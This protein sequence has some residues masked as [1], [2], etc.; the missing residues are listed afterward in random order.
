M[1]RNS[2]TPRRDAQ[3]YGEQSASDYSRY[4]RS[5]GA[6]QQD[7]ARYSRSSMGQAAN[8]TDYSQPVDASRY[9]RENVALQQK[10]ARRKRRN[11][12]IFT[13]VGVVLLLVVVVGAGAAFAYYKT[14]SDNLSKGVTD[15][16]LQALG[17]TTYTGD[18]FYMLLLGT[19]GASWR[20]EDPEFDGIY[21]TDSMMLVRVDP[22]NVQVSMISLQRDTLVDMGTY[23]ENKLNAAYTLG[24]A[25]Y[26]I[27]VVEQLSGVDISHYGEVNIDGLYNVVEA[28]GGVEVEVP[29]EINDE[30]AG[31]HLDAGWQ[32]LDGDGVLILCRS[33][34]TYDEYG[35]G[36]E[37]R[38][39]NQRMVL[40]AIA[41]KILD[42]DLP[43]I[44]S[45]VNAISENVA[46]DL[47][48]P[49]ILSIANTMRGIDPAT[50]IYSAQMPTDSA[51][52]NDTWYEI[53]N[54]PAWTTMMQRMDAGLPPAS[55]TV[56]DEATGVIISS[57]GDGS[58]AASYGEEVPTAAASGTKGAI[59]VRN[60]GGIEGA[61][62]KAAAVFQNM[63]YTT[64]SA[65]AESMS[66]TYS[67]VVYSSS[68]QQQEAAK[69][70]AALG[71]GKTML[72][73]G[74]YTIPTGYDFLVVVGSDYM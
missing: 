54:V 53:L 51:Y 62:A 48:V 31:G 74:T 19:D 16:T 28:I 37:M 35:K 38:A 22:Q 72:N 17:D 5:G 46:T 55:E 1:A 15:E 56:I 20:D 45:A 65:N 25:A 42:S 13:V 6:Q 3:I 57:N 41:K 34:H 29:M 39:A 69:L 66:Y 30:E 49:D 36:D 4:S 23:G 64:D 73:D 14:I 60:G 68:S 18:P 10:K 32:T 40:G 33:R 44:I 11:R 61:A 2:R 26:A 7:Y 24:G 27:T 59:A 43:T 70:S 71:T 9:S 47:S 52:L 8:A 50:D 67:L 58:T 12:T 21:R 63:G